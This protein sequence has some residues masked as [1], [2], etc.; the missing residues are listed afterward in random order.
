MTNRFKITFIL[1]I[2]LTSCSIKKDTADLNIELI[3]IHLYNLKKYKAFEKLIKSKDESYNHFVSVSEDI[4]PFFNSHKLKRE[5]KRFIRKDKSKFIF[6]ANYYYDCNY[7]V[8]LILYEWNYNGFNYEFKKEFDSITNHLNK[9]LGHYDY[10]NIGDTIVNE[11]RKDQIKWIKSET[12]A[13]LF[14]FKN[15]FNQ[16]RLAVYKD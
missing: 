10:I 4:Y 8:K 5:S 14:R 3:D 13:Y 2:V 15:N 1:L 7:N 16:I 11:T 6:E 12:K 9:I